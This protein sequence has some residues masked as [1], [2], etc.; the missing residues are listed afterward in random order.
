MSKMITWRSDV[1]HLQFLRQ[2]SQNAFFG[3]SDFVLLFKTVLYIFNTR[4]RHCRI[5]WVL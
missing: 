2:R 3:I 5:F 1:Y 4:T